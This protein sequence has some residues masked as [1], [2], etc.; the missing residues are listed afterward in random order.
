MHADKTFDS[1]ILDIDG[2]IWNTTD[3]VAVAWN[4]AIARSGFQAPPVN[5][6]L[7][8]KE[9]GKTMDVIA[10]DL[11]PELDAACR[12][13]LM[14]LC[15][16]EEQRALRENEA[17]ISYPGVSAGVRSLS[18]K[19]PVFVVSNCQ[20]GY[21]ELTLAKLGLLD[22]V[23]DFECFG[24]TGKG[25]ADNLR[26]LIGRNSLQAPVYVGDTQGD[27]DA[28]AGAGVPFIWA[29]YGFGSADPYYAKIDSFSQLAAFF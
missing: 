6:K 27:C 4:R 21:I 16:E 19:I 17:D 10:L 15:C 12:T 2:T 13:R 29:A 8:Q 3:V 24:R 11:W 23:K 9:F 20:A 26:L 18:E 25:K 1:L 7:L 14:A 5:G 22:C 28:C